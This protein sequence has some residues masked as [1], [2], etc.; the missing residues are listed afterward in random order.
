MGLNQVKF[1]LPFVFGIAA[2]VF[3]TE[4]EEDLDLH[5]FHYRA[6]LVLEEKQNILGALTEII[7]ESE[8]ATEI[9]QLR[10]FAL[11]NKTISNMRALIDRINSDINII[12]KKAHSLGFFGAKIYHKILVKNPNNINVN[13][14]VDLQQIYNLKL[15]IKY[16]NRNKEFNETHNEIMQSKLRIFK[17]SIA[18]IKALIDVAVRDL[19]KNGFY[20]P[21]ILEK[22]VRVNYEASEAILYLAIDPGKKVHFGDTE[23]KA[24]SGIDEEFIRN[25]IVWNQGEV[26]DIE[27]IESTVE[28][29]KNTQIFSNVKAEP[30]NS[31]PE[32]TRIPILLELEEDKKHM[33]DFTLLYS[34][35]RSMNFEKKS[36]AQQKLKSIIARLSWS[37]CNAFDG[38]EKLTLT[39]EG[40]PL[41]AQSKRAD[42]GFEATLAQPDVFF[43]NNTAHYTIS[44]KQELTNVFFRKSD[45]IELA[46]DYP[47]LRDVLLN[48]DGDLE[49]NYVDGPKIFSHDSDRKNYENFSP[50]IGF[51]LDKTDD[52]LNPTSGYRLFAKFSE[53]FF[54]HS[55]VNSLMALDAGFSYN[56]P[57][58]DLKRTIV[59]FNLQRKSILGASIDDIPLDKRIYAGGMNSIRG[60]ANQMATEMVIG[61]DVVMGGKSSTEFSAEIRRKFT[62]DFG[63]VVFFD[64][65]KI[66]QNKS[67]YDNLATEKKRWFFSIGFGLRYFSSIGPIRIDLAFPIKRRR[68]VDSRMQFVV[69]L[70]QAF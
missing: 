66:F 55:S 12:Y 42:Y 62:A 2:Y 47:L 46:Y 19:Q 43:R 25:R 28:N 59:A 27:K 24:F 52:L 29:L 34:G 1:S 68:A 3:A 26:F 65:A 58:D 18:E 64:G 11:Q 40:T 49:R 30:I 70:G 20:E 32:N 39:V 9:N 36:Q 7:S 4:S 13:I 37:N 21:K 53:I 16:L 33:V 31:R 15:N 50:S 41:R 63:G 8:M 54:K 6:N 51:I 22:K 69:S 23:I 60:Y 48:I 5:N 61:E 14:Y 35:M 38:G 44:R 56:L 10:T 57:L 17:A 45:K 67:R